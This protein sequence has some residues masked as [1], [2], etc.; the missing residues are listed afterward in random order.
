MIWIQI[1]KVPKWKV[2]E[3]IFNCGRSDSNWVNPM[4]GPWCWRVWKLWWA[5]IIKLITLSPPP[6]CVLQMGYQVSK[7]NYGFVFKFIYLINLCY[8][9]ALNVISLKQHCRSLRNASHVVLFLLLFLF[10]YFFPHLFF[11]R[12]DVVCL[13]RF[14]GGSVCLEIIMSQLILFWTKFYLILI[15]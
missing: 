9:T 6:Q 7:I 3:V 11:S 13:G 14:S 5:L 10:F 1:C 15:F 4:K 2:C 8:S 12:W